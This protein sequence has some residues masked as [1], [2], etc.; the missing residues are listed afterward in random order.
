[1][2][3][4]FLGLYDWI[5]IPIP[6]WVAVESLVGTVR[7]RLQMVPQAPFVRNVTFTLMGVPHIQASAVPL[8]KAF[9]NVLDFANGFV[10]SSIA[11]AYD[12]T[13]FLRLRN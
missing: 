7:L 13:L 8:I 6:I 2:I 10:Q 12:F 4:F 11:A 3:E 9:P 1:M 5:H